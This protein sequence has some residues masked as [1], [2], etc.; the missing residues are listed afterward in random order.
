MTHTG[1]EW[2]GNT[3]KQFEVTPIGYAYDYNSYF[4]GYGDGFRDLEGNDMLW[5]DQLSYV[6]RAIKF[7][8]GLNFSKRVVDS[9]INT[10]TKVSKVYEANFEVSEKIQSG[11]LPQPSKKEKRILIHSRSAILI[12]CKVRKPGMDITSN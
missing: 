12:S 4:D 7:Q 3:F 10:K 8:D 9:Q 1:Q 2:C 5:E 11:R 6:L